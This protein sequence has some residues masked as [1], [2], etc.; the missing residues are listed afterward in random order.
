MNTGLLTTVARN[1]QGFDILLSRKEREKMA[2][3]RYQNPTLQTT[4][5]QRPKWYVQYWKDVIGLDKQWKRIQDR[6]Y[7][8]F[9]DEVG[10]NEAKRRRATFLQTINREVYKL[11]SHVNFGQFVEHLYIPKHVQVNLGSNSQQ[12]YLSL[13]HNHIV[14]AFSRF[15]LC[16]IDT[17][18]IADFLALKADP[19][20][21]TVDGKEKEKPGLSWATRTDL[22]NI[23]SGIYT[24]AADHGY[25]SDHDR[26]PAERASAGKK[27]AVREKRILTEEQT[28]KLLAKLRPD[29]RLIAQTAVDVGARISEILGL[30]WKRVDLTTGWIEIEKRWSRGDEDVTKSERSARPAPLG[31]LVDE[32]RRLALTSGAAVVKAGQILIVKPEQVVFERPSADGES[33]D[34]RIIQNRHLRPAAIELG[35]YFP[36]FGMHAL[37]RANVTWRQQYGGMNS[38]EAAL[39]VGHSKPSMTAEYTVLQRARNEE[40][41]RK[42]QEHRIGKPEGGV[43]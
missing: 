6:E 27:R 34:D 41:V 38:I 26:N 21:F 18:M 8:G 22:R 15:K 17:E 39:S 31:N 9:C 1:S 28:C 37:R 42:I 32:Y 13:L 24:W 2:R 20:I 40:A 4:D 36:G 30:R 7:F 19:T 11:Q 12:K 5:A 16:E 25:W 14:P 35:F 33:W 10:V 3:R 29:V 23:L 43:S